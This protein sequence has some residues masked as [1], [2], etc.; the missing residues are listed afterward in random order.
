M[1]HKSREDLIADEYFRHLNGTLAFI[2][3]GIYFSIIE[4][5]HFQSYAILSSTIIFIYITFNFSEY[6]SISKSYTDRYKGI[7]KV[8]NF[9]RIGI[10]VICY[11]LLCSAAFG[12]KLVNLISI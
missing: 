11:A 9:L 1:I 10:F 2:I 6:S 3:L 12:Y 5:S 4:S 8:F 7:S